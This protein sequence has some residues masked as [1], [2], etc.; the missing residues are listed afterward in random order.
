MHLGAAHDRRIFFAAAADA[1]S[2]ISPLSTAIS[3]SAVSTVLNC[4]VY[5]TPSF[6]EA[7]FR[8]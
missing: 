2:A 1:E 3:R 4:G 5:S 7:S 6:C 8:M